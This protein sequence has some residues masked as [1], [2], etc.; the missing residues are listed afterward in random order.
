MLPL[1]VIALL[2]VIA[3]DIWAAI[4]TLFRPASGRL[5]RI[6]YVLVFVTCGIV[7]YTATGYERRL[8]E[9]TRVV[10]WPVPV[11]IY[12]RDDPNSPWLD[13]VGPTTVFGYPLNLAIFMFVP[14]VLFL[15]LHYWWHQRTVRPRDE[16]SADTA[17][18]P[19]SVAG[20]GDTRDGLPGGR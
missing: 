20:E 1:I 4:V 15:G 17:E 8:N 16:T 3:G 10:G 5:V 7:A 14:S 6:A 13:F 11:V 18:Q 9:N 19:R 2:A 12:Q